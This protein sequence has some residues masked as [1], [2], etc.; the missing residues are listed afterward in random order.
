MPTLAGM[1]RRGVPA[2]AIRRFCDRIGVSKRNSFVDV[3]LLEHEVREELN[4]RC[5]RVLAVIRPLRVTIEN[6]PEGQTETFDAPF[7]PAPE[8]EDASHGTRPI[9]LS[10]TIYVERDDFAKVPPKG[11]FRLAP[12]AEV[13][14]R[15]AC[16]IRCKEV[17]ENAQ[18][19]VTELVCTWDPDTRG[20]VAKDGRKV[21]GTIHWV[22]ERDAVDAEVR[23]YDR[24]FSTEQPGETEGKDFLEEINPASLEIVRGCRVEPS[25]RDA[26]PG[27]VVQFERLGYFCVDAESK[28]GALVFNRTIGLRDSWAKQAG[29]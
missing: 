21:K 9:R 1:R 29:K 10:R 12:G 23:L 20:G 6:F 25:L 2:V 19:E 14:L 3:S 28:P 22:S 26:K 17:K 16:F 27:D 7:H 11:W 8:P 15:Y 13:R 5:K 18:G 24:L 4:A